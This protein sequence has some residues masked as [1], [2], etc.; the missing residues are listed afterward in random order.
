MLKEGLSLVDIASIVL[1]EVKEPMNLYDLFETVIKRKEIKVGDT[2]DLLTSFYADLTVS[3][4]FVYTGENMWDLKSNQKIE[5]WEKD[6]SFFK[7]YTEIDIPEE[8][9]EEEKPKPVK[10]K[11]KP[12]KVAPTPV[13][14]E[15]PVVEVEPVVEE[16]PVVEVAPVVVKPKASDVVDAVK[17]YEEATAEEFDEELFD[18]FD[19][20]KYNEY[21]DTYEDQYDK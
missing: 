11:A 13:V 16:E 3:A 21:M 12:V 15:K 4:K 5:L 9:L 19:E 17:E 20:E 1:L 8:Y 2:T 14:E 7:E 6:G 18:D 10:A